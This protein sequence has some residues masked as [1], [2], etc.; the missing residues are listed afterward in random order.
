[1]E[2]QVRKLQIPGRV[3]P[4]GGIPPTVSM[5]VREC[6]GVDQ[7]RPSGILRCTHVCI[8]ECVCGLVVRS[9][10]RVGFSGLF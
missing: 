1:M 3:S 8:G 6:S 10:R 4:E 9:G 7:F 5:R 2:W